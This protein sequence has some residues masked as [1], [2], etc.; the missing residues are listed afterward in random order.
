MDQL[1]DRFFS[2]SRIFL[3]NFRIFRI[4]G[5]LSIFELKVAKYMERIR[6]IKIESKSRSIR[7]IATRNRSNQTKFLR[8]RNSRTAPSALSS[9]LR[10]SK[11]PVTLFR[12]FVT[13]AERIRRV[14]RFNPP[15]VAKLAA[16]LPA[17][18]NV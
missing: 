15:I 18:R 17:Y 7:T 5:I 11:F 3:L 12:P 13:G 8:F 14:P 6:I 2:L 4:H 10:V 9:R 16:F 1:R